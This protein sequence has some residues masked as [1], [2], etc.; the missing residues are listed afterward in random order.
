V[1][2]ALAKARQ[3]ATAAGI[4]LGPVLSIRESA[5][6]Q[7]IPMRTMALRAESTPIEPGQLEVAVAVD[8]RV[9]IQR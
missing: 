2:D 9:A 4:K 7:P 8:L 1:S 6:S 5:V 3:L